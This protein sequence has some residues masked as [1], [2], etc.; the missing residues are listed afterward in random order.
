MWPCWEW[1]DHPERRWLFASYAESLSVRDNV[2]SR[3]LIQSPWYAANWADRFELAGDQNEKRR[4][5]NTKGGHRIAI[6]TGGS[7][8][9]EGGDR[10]II[11]DP[12]NIVEIES[13]VCRRGVLSWFD[14]VFITRRN[15]PQTS[16]MVLILQRSHTDDLAGHVLEMG[17]WEC[18]SLPTEYEGDKRK[19]VIGW[20]DPRTTEGELLWPSRFGAAEIAEAK[21]TLGSF[22][23]SAQHQQ[24][25]V[26]AGG[27]IWKKA[28][29]RFYRR[30]DLPT[31]FDVQISSW[32][33]AFKDLSTSDYVCGQLWG[34]I[35]AD[36]YLLDQI[37]GHLDSWIKDR[38]QEYFNIAVVKP[39]VTSRLLR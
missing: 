1:I 39:R 35:G 6:G 28:W 26:P 29:F 24:R 37:H 4:I 10:L 33:A 3:R 13:D 22:A 16:A 27:G 34:R 11:D 25:P 17:G 32:D 12:H 38:K 18:L 15:N 9:G 21:K 36:F 2:R 20:S 14:T 7:A 30:S 5:E 19:T 8:T 23:F 31:K